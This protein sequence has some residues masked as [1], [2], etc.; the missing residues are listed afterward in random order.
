MVNQ[1]KGL[2][3]PQSQVA[4]WLEVLGTYNFEIEN[5]S[6]LKHNNAESLS[7]G[8]CL[9]WGLHDTIETLNA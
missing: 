1:L 5:R 3:D 2:K 9:Q 7:R 8:P 6:G 4:R